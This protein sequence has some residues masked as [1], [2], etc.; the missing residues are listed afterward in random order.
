[1]KKSFQQH[2]H[3]LRGVAISLIVIAHTLPSLDWRASPRMEGWLDAL[4]NQASIIFFFIAGYL[5][6][7][8]SPRFHYRSY[9]WQ[10]LRTVILPYLILSV[11]ALIVFTVLT[12]RQHLFPGF[13]DMPVWKQIG[14]FLLTGKHLAPLWFVPTITLF[15]LAAPLLLWVDRRQPRLYWLILPLLVL[16][17]CI[18]RGGQLGPLNYALYLLPVYLL[19]MVFSHHSE[20]ALQLV[21]RWR[22][23]LLAVMLLCGT[24]H[25]LDWAEPPYW[26]LPSKVAMALLLTWALSRWHGKIG[27]RLD[28]IAD[29]SFGI[30]FIHAYFILALKLIAVYVLEGRVY[31]GVGEQGIPGN[32]FTFLVYAGLVMLVSVLVLRLA[33]RVFG[34][35]SRMIVGA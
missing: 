31:N 10:K 24:G 5:F 3:V 21:G 13:Y 9:L 35:R 18:G 19:G 28:E 25:A 20:R 22:L 26:L 8:L 12:H 7:H 27:H 1:M 23:P 4:G 16:G 2:I 6:Q 15:Y 33:R 30:F 29:L 14:I 17:A 11:P 34:A 32:L